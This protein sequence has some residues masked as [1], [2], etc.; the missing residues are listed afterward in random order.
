[1]HVFGARTLRAK[2][3]DGGIRNYVLKCFIKD[4]VKLSIGRPTMG[5]LRPPRVGCQSKYHIGNNRKL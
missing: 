3:H 1:M 4:P 5:G 2:K